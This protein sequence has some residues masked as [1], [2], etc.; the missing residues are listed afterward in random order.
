MTNPIKDINYYMSLPYSILISPHEETD[1]DWFA[2][3][4]DLSGCMTQAPSR[5]ELFELIE[6]AKRLWIKAMLE[7][8]QPIPEPEHSLGKR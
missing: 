4:P 1:D 3:I 2:E 5:D 8:G 6:E 7:M